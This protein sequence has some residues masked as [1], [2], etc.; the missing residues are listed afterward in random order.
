MLSSA[1]AGQR[2]FIERHAGGLA[3][4]MA[5]VAKPVWRA[6][7]C[8]LAMTL[9]LV[10]GAL[11]LPVISLCARSPSTSAISRTTRSWWRRTATNISRALLCRP[12]TLNEHPH[13]VGGKDLR[14]SGT[15]LG[16]NEHGM[17]A[18]LLNRRTADYGPTDPALR[19]RGLLCLDALQ[20]PTAA[21]AARY[22]ERQRGTAL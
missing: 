20:Q 9:T 11:N 2:G 14:A 15:W 12:T 7:P 6:H 8:G 10:L 13:V 21:A 22:A 18:G 4:F 1:A 16:V 3:H 5:C 17:V 19:S